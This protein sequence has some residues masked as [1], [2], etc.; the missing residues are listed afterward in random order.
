LPG[1][2]RHVGRFDALELR[3]LPGNRHQRPPFSGEHGSVDLGDDGRR[4]QRQAEAPEN[5]LVHAV[6]GVAIDTAELAVVLDRV[7]HVSEIR[8][9]GVMEKRPQGGISVGTSAGSEIGDEA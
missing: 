2:D 8:L 3:P 6:L 7:G 9:G 5:G 1:I 4:P